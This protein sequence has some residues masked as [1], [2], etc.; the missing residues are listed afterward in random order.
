MNSIQ[1]FQHAFNHKETCKVPLDWG[2]HLISGIHWKAYK[3]LVD[4]LDVDNK[5]INIERYRHQTA[6][7]DESILQRFNIDT[8]PIVPA[9]P[10]LS[11]EEDS[12]YNM[13][14]DEWGNS[15]KKEKK[16][17]LY[18]ELDKSQFDSM[19]SLSELKKAEWADY[20]KSMRINGIKEKF[21]KIKK[22]D[23]V[24]IVDLPLGLEIFDAGFNLCGYSNFYMLLALDPKSACYIMDRQL[25]EQLKWWKQVI[26]T[27]PELEFI[28]IGDD[29]GSQTAMLIDPRMY[30]KLVKPRHEKLIKG[31]KDY[32]KGK[33]KIIMHCDGAIV[34]IIPDFIKMG[35]DCLNPIQY[36]VDGMNPV[37]LKKEFGKDIVLWGGGVD[38]QSVLP[39]AKPQEVKDVVRRQI[40]ILAP[41]GGFVFS[42]IHIIQADVPP[43]NIVAMLEAVNEY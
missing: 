31:I 27:L 26:D 40:D 1:V 39:N 2:G 17:G 28:R 11:W 33:I 9:W 13:Y 38:T 14:T 20:G 7:I 6:I 29:L 25:E 41:G 4:Y 12:L 15:W 36:T 24:P 34:P 35:I 19:P 21:D 8:R 10:D 18:Y 3:N 43:E 22:L 32:S 42:Q 30:R 5:T 37:F 16:A 23:K